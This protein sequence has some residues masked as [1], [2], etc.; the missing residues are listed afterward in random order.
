MSSITPLGRVLNALSSPTT[1]ARRVSLR[2]ASGVLFL[3]TGASAATT[4]T[5]TEANAATGGTSQ[6]LVGTFQYFTQAAATGVWTQGVGGVNGTSI[7]SIANAAANLA[8]YIPQGALSDGFSYLAGSHAT[9][10]FQYVLS[11]IDVKRFPPN[12]RDVTA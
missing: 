6:T 2:D 11:D 4:V 9:G 10:T 3:M 8:V 12:L 1:T 7:T 5:I